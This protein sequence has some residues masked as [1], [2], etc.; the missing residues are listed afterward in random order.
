[1]LYGC[2]WDLGLKVAELEIAYVLTCW[3]SRVGLL[4]DIAA[5]LDGA[6]GEVGEYSD[7]LFLEYILQ[8]YQ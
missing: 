7:C 1:M 2:H 8:I 4:V 5:E 6:Y 3:A